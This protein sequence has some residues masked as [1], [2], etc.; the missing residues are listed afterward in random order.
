MKKIASHYQA[1]L[2]QNSQFQK[3]VPPCVEMKKIDVELAEDGGDKSKNNFNNEFYE[4][5]ARL[6]GTRDDWFIIHLHFWAAIDFKEIKQI[7]AYSVMN[8]VGNAAGCLGLVLGVSISQL[9]VW[10]TRQIKTI[11]KNKT[12]SVDGNKKSIFSTK[13]NLFRNASLSSDIESKLWMRIVRTYIVLT[14]EGRLNH[15]LLAFVRALQDAI[16]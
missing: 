6:A 4:Q 16:D 2:Y 5:F 8:A 13:N 3:V 9:I 1:Q 14:A 7:R 10:V 15:L 12:Q 11:Y